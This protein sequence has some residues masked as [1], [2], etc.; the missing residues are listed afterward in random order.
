ML[1]KRANSTMSTLPLRLS[2]FSMSTNFLFVVA[3]GRRGG[4]GGPEEKEEEEE[5]EE[6]P[7][8]SGKGP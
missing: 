8:L 1:T 2:S 7:V 5:E 4:T 6:K 3:L